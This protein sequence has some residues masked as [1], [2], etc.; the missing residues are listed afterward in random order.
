MCPTRQKLAGICMPRGGHDSH[1]EEDCVG[2]EPLVL[3]HSM[4][5]SRGLQA[6]PTH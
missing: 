4:T 3:L 6:F 1:L 5:S 2:T